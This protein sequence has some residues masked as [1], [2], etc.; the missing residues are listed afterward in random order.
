WT[1]VVP[2]IIR[3]AIALFFNGIYVLLVIFALYFLCQRKLAGK[4]VLI[5]AIAVMFIFAMVGMALQV[6]STMLELQTLYAAVHNE[7]Q[8]GQLNSP[9]RLSDALEFVGLFL[10][11]AN[12][13][14]TDLFL[15][16]RCYLIW[17]TSH[18]KKVVILPLFLV[19]VTTA[20]SFP[21]SNSDTGSPATTLFYGFA[22][23]LMDGKYPWI[24]SRWGFNWSRSVPS[25]TLC[26]GVESTLYTMPVHLKKNVLS[27]IVSATPFCQIGRKYNREKY[28]DIAE[29]STYHFG[30][31]YVSMPKLAT[32]PPFRSF[33]VLLPH[34]RAGY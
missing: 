4:R 25:Q 15:T 27:K 34:P 28:S 23:Q 8:D 17:G 3:T 22:N 18:K 11:V 5:C 7:G 32:N 16:Y 29:T 14:I 12:N 9:T 10:L 13:A 2:D 1:F 31:P 20:S 33:Y 26:F 21:G 19:L 24:D 6:V 30:F